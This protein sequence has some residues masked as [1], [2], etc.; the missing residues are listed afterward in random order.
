MYLS[1][2]G[3]LYLSEE[4]V[5]G[6]IRQQYLAMVA[7]LDDEVGRIVDALDRNGLTE[8]TVIWFLSDNGADPTFGGSN[9]PLRG[10]KRS[11]Y[12]GGLRVPSFVGWPGHIAP[13][14]TAQ[15]GTNV[16]ILPT[17]L[18]LAGLPLNH[19]VDGVDLSS[20]LLGGPPSPAAS[21]S[22]TRSSATRTGWAAGSSSAATPVPGSRTRPSSTTSRRTLP[23]PPTSRTSTP[24]PSPRSS[25]GSP[26]G[27][28]RAPTPWGRRRAA[29]RVRGRRRRC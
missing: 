24:T 25:A 28:R 5:A 14:A 7:V 9:G 26:T 20:H 19:D 27:S 3:H 17:L 10:K 8:H 11:P 18:G 21:P 22:R 23:R 12:E 4:T 1:R 13:G 2:F 16:D 15:L 6:Y 29:A